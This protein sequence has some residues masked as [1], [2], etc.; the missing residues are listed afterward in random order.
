MNFPE[1]IFE[2]LHQ[3]HTK[4]RVRKILRVFRTFSGVAISVA[5]II[6][7]SKWKSTWLIIILEKCSRYAVERCYWKAS[8]KTIPVEEENKES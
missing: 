1:D 8:A 7:E 6:G 4:V 3:R 5:E 2:S